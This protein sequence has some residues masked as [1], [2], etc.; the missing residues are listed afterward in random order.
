MSE[1]AVPIVGSLPEHWPSTIAVQPVRPWWVPW[2]I[3]VLAVPLLWILPK[4]TGP[5]FAAIRWPGVIVAH[6]LWTLYG[7][8]CI[9]LAVAAPECGWIAWF[10]D[11]GAGER[12]A[13]AQMT[14]SQTA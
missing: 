5:H 4:R 8:A 1:P 12:P 9:Y 2:P 14:F 13:Y 11:S 7:I 10:K 3:A 6:L